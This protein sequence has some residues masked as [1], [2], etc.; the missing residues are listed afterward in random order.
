MSDLD[1]HIALHQA[2]HDLSRITR[3]LEDL[4][5]RILGPEP[6]MT[7][8]SQVEKGEDAPTLSA[9]LCGGPDALRKF[10]DDTCHRIKEL[11]EV[12]F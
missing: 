7:D 12:L 11:E 10:T 1:K 9:V 6:A 8:S 3:N 4:R 2:I 5:Q